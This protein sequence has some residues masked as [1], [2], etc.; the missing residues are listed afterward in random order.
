MCPQRRCSGQRPGSPPEGR[1][2]HAFVNQAGELVADAGHVV[3]I[4]DAKEAL[5]C[6]YD[7]HP[8]AP[9]STPLSWDEVAPDLD[10]KQFTMPAVLERV[11]QQGD[12]YAGVLTTRQS[13][14][15]ALAAIS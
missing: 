2:V 5:G 6:R 12:I 13:L 8:G 10:P 11:E 15:K 4:G 3:L 1:R 14:A 7:P 9:V